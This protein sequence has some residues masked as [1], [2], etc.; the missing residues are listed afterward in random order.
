M[1][2]SIFYQTG[3]LAKVLFTPGMSKIEQKQMGY[4]ANAKTLET[5][6]EVWNELGIFTKEMYG[7]KDLQKLNGEHIGAYMIAKSNQNIT[8]Q[9][10]ELIS[11]AIGKLEVALTKFYDKIDLGTPSEHRT[12]DFSVRKNILNGAREQLLVKET[13]DEPTFARNYEN[14][15]ALIEAIIDE[16]HQLAAWIQYESGARLEA[17]LR[18]DKSMNIKTSKLKDNNLEDIDNKIIDGIYSQVNQMQG[19]KLDSF[20]NVEKGQ[21]FTVEKGGKPGIV[22]ISVSTYLKLQKFLEVDGVFEINVNHYRRA[23]IGA[24]NETSQ[25]YNGTHGL[26]WNFAQKRFRELQILGNLTYEQALQQV[27]WEMKHERA[28]ITEHYLRISVN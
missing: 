3:E 21:L 13:S 9:R 16:K 26:R 15:K 18:I 8:E 5:Y 6:R 19:I 25:Q 1:R 14:P 4:V 27:S 7:I 2:G 10:L 12:Y 22:Q 20:D 17:V 23:L 24:A 11:S 28:E